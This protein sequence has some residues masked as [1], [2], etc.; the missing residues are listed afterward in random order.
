MYM[1]HYAD[2]I[3]LIVDE[4]DDLLLFNFNFNSLKFN[5]KTSVGKTK[6]MTTS[7]VPIRYKLKSDGRMEEQA[8]EFKY[9]G[10]TLSIRGIW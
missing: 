10:V 1:V 7:E 4:E 2:D 6:A 5:V 3:A 8:I 9:W